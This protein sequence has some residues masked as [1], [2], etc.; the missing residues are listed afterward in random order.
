MI[1][2][3]VGLKSPSKSW[4]EVSR[5]TT[6]RQGHLLHLV[7]VTFA[8]SIVVGVT[9]GSEGA[10]HRLGGLSREASKAQD[11]TDEHDRLSEEGGVSRDAPCQLSIEPSRR[12]GGGV[13][14]V[15]SAL[16]LLLLLAAAA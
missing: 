13:C 10:D 15:C 8:V 9:G 3:V 1:P 11:L 12:E 5:E 7:V 4:T 6:R 16:G 14:F 2:M